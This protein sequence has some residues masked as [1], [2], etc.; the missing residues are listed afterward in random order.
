MSLK[1]YN[2]TLSSVESKIISSSLTMGDQYLNMISTDQN[3]KKTETNSQ[4][5]IN[6]QTTKIPKI[7]IRILTMNQGH[8]E[9]YIIQREGYMFVGQHIIPYQII[10]WRIIHVLR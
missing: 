10:F 5:T 7:L 9:L 6:Y 3:P 2:S 8:D 4:K 1:I